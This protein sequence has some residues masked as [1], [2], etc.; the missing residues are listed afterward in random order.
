MPK[1]PNAADVQD[2]MEEDGMEGVWAEAEPA[3]AS[4]DERPEPK[5]P[6]TATSEPMPRAETTSGSSSS[7]T[8]EAVGDEFRLA[9]QEWQRQQEA[10]APPRGSSHDPNLAHCQVLKERSLHTDFTKF[11]NW[12]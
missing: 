7:T 10:R 11:Q 12:Q 8:Q 2:G 6:R 3:D 1:A 9:M 4:E 5:K